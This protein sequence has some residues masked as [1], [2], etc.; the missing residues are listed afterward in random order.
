MVGQSSR[1][2]EFVR[3]QVAR[4][5]RLAHHPALL[6]ALLLSAMRSSTGAVVEGHRNKMHT[7]EASHRRGGGA[8]GL[9]P[10]SL[11]ASQ[12][13]VEVARLCGLW[14]SYTECTVDEAERLRAFVARLSRDV[15]A[16]RAA[17]TPARVKDEQQQGDDA[18]MGGYSMADS[19]LDEIGLIIDERLDFILH[20]ARYTLSTARYVR[21]RSMD[22]IPTVSGQDA[23]VCTTYCFGI[24]FVTDNPRN[25]VVDG[26]LHHPR[27]LR[28]HG[29]P[30]HQRHEAAQ[31]HLRSAPGLSAWD[32]GH[33][34]YATRR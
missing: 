15:E 7:T 29:Q 5:A 22:F 1:Q 20:K 3:A 32:S 33:S 11:Y 9:S 16:A 8:L 18:G 31:G 34:K 23:V 4:L 25:G 2:S 19:D 26:E 17:A 30:A 10:N 13:L 12:S 28:P 24:R 14:V 27:S 6:P 21:E